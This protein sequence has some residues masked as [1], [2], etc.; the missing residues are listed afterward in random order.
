[1]AKHD[2][3]LTSVS[4]VSGVFSVSTDMSIGTAN[5]EKGESIGVITDK[6]GLFYADKSENKYDF[7]ALTGGEFG[8]TDGGASDGGASIKSFD[9]SGVASAIKITVDNSTGKNGAWGSIITGSGKDVVSVVSVNAGVFDLGA[10]NDSITFSV[11]TATVTLGDGKD[12]ISIAASDA[13]VEIADYN[14]ADDTILFA[15]TDV[16]VNYDA[17]QFVAQGT[18]SSV[19]IGAEM[20]DGVYELKLSDGKNAASHYVRTNASAADYVATDAIDF[21]S[22][23]DT[24]AL[25]LTLA[26]KTSNTVSVKATEGAINIAVGKADTASGAKGN[27]ITLG[28]AD[29]ELGLGI[30]K[31]SG[32]VSVS[33]GKS[34]MHLD[35]DDTLY[36]LDGGKLSDIQFKAQ[37]SSD[38]N[39]VY[40]NATIAAG[41]SSV[42]GTFNYNVGGQ[43]GVLMYG[44]D[45]DKTVAYT[46]GVSYYANASVV[47]ASSYDDDVVLSLN[48][49]TE[50]AFSA[51]VK[52]ISG[53]MSGLVAG[54]YNENTTVSVST[55][56]NKKTEVYGGIGGADLIDFSEADEDSTNVVWYS[57]GDGKDTVKAF[58]NGDNSVYFHGA[59]AAAGIL[60]DVLDAA[61]A[62]SDVNATLTLAKGKDVL[63]LEGV[64]DKTITFTDAASNNFKVAFG[65]GKEV[66]YAADVNIYKGATTLKVDGSDDLIIYTGANNDQYG[67][68][69]GITKIDASEAKGTLAISGTNANGMEILGGTGVNNMWGGGDKAQTLTGN[70]DAV[71]VFWFGSGDGHDIAKNAKAEDGVNLYNVENIDDVAVKASTNYF[72]VTVG[73][74][75]LKVNVDSTAT[76]ADVLEKFTFADK[77]GVLYTYNT[78]TS[79]FQQK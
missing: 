67:Y 6:N 71:N 63:T 33:V 25:N 49:D 60:N 14:F 55:D 4:V 8:F 2:Y 13:S 42:G 32:A 9:G 40:G 37:T 3:S 20:T 41:Y 57:N 73:S 44:A 43:T 47:D 22:E 29:V 62:S 7:S 79:K 56:A 19:T 53:V 10:G 21:M 1:M 39:I 30:S 72:T 68:F 34:T 36:L 48:G 16:S 28:S 50:D 46:E 69:D 59:T 77:A 15:A 5:L 76:A 26:D 11:G 70:E 23:S 35:E 75:S 65:D 31:N 12:T 38:G 17:R 24:T 45:A 58:G 64:K 51:D 78:K 66:T 61:S 54:R 27:A 52:V 18:S 74:D